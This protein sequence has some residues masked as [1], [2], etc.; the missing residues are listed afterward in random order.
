MPAKLTIE[1]VREKNKQREPEY[2]VLGEY[3]NNSTKIDVRHNVCGRVYK[4][5]MSH[6]WSGRNCP[7]CANE[8]RNDERNKQG[9]KKFYE[10]L[11]RLHLEPVDSNYK[12]HNQRD[13]LEVKC[14]VCGRVQK[15]WAVN[16]M[17]NHGCK[18]CGAKKSGLKE[19]F[20]EKLE[21]YPDWELVGDYVN[22]TTPT[23]FR[24]IP[25]GKIYEKAPYT[26]TSSLDTCYQCRTSSSEKEVANFV[27]QFEPST[28][29]GVRT[30]L[31]GWK[32][33]DIFVPDKHIA[34][35]F[36]GI[37]THSVETLM[38]KTKHKKHPMTEREATK[39]HLDKTLEAETK[40]IRLIHIFEDE[41]LYRR[42]IV[43]DKIKAYLKVPMERI[44]ARNTTVKEID[45]KTGNDFLE[46]NHIQ[47]QVKDGKIYIGLF[48]NDELVAVQSYEKLRK[49]SGGSPGKWA[50][51]RYATKLGVNIIGGFSK[52]MKYFERNFS[53]ILIVSYADLRWTDRQNN[54]YLSNGFVPTRIN[55]PTYWYIRQRQRYHRFGFSKKEIKKRF[56]EIYSDEKTEKEMMR[57]QKYYRLYDCGTIRYEYKP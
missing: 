19:K 10:Q 46:E 33:L 47:G 2:T 41:W 34:F 5:D 13:V 28:L 17:T 21:D 36:D 56:P 22:A 35:E 7:Y 51:N 39:Y 43:E 48:Y 6:F 49:R 42:E 53:P 20:L 38:A 15:S 55:P 23:K 16:I 12:Y 8:H 30:I 37:F 27:K 44:Y 45:K 32:E 1:Q 4:T 25:C 50:L 40:G 54:V 3:V 29:T 52:C 11:K 26:V 24:H 14:S 31:D 18:A 9:E 57:E